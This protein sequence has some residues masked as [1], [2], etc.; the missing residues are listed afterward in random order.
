MIP[1]D[2]A[3]DGT[4]SVTEGVDLYLGELMRLWQR[5]RFRHVEPRKSEE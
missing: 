2:E 1:A 5:H 4:A 3:L